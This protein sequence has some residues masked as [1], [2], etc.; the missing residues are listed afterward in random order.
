MNDVISRAGQQVFLI[1]HQEET[2]RNTAFLL[3]LAGYGV[4]TAAGLEEAINTISVFCFQEACPTIILLNNL[5]STSDLKKMLDLLL[6]RC[7]DS[8]LLVVDRGAQADTLNELE[9]QV[10][11]P[12]HILT[13]VRKILSQRD[14][15]DTISGTS[16][17]KY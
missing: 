17:S 12:R 4:K 15:T 3:R 9:Q 2:L 13:E 5:Q 16:S 7:R 6:N 14:S 8:K 1:D 10:V 11:S